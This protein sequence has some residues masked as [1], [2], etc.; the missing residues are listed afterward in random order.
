MKKSVKI[1]IFVGVLLLW[2]AVFLY[3][4]T[5]A[6]HFKNVFF[7]GWLALTAAGAYILYVALFFRNKGPMFYRSQEGPMGVHTMVFNKDAFPSLKPLKIIGILVVVYFLA[8]VLSSAVILR[9][10]A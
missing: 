8:S 4:T 3:V 5:P 2:A 7:M 10:K 1:G 6:I 9:S